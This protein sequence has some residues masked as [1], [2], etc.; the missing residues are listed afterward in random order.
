MFLSPTNIRIRSLD[1]RPHP[2]AYGNTEHIFFSKENKQMLAKFATS[3]ADRLDLEDTTYSRFDI[4]KHM[5]RVFDA[6]VGKAVVDAFQFS[7]DP[8]ST[9]LA[10]FLRGSGET[11]P[12]RAADLEELNKS[13]KNVI[14]NHVQEQVYNQT[15]YG[16]AITINNGS[17]ATRFHKNAPYPKSIQSEA[18]ADPVQFAI[19]RS[20]PY[21]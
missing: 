1:L 11:P 5:K 21:S 16:Q 15:F 3:E 14:R 2:N 12:N 4:Q 20:N 10:L 6:H 19:R 17:G 18:V 13:M 8:K 9:D 7:V